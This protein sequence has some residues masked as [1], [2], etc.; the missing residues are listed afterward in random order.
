MLYRS[1]DLKRNGTLDVLQSEVLLYF[2]HRFVVV[3]FNQR[4]KFLFV[5]RCGFS[6]SYP[7]FETSHHILVVHA[8]K[9]LNDYVDTVLV[10]VQISRYMSAD[11]DGTCRRM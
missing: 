7:F 10:R 5:R 1:K 6:L 9:H 3:R 2:L 4:D 11:A 8:W